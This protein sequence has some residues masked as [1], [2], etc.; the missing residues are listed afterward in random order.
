MSGDTDTYVDPY[1]ELGSVTEYTLPH[2]LARV[3][4]GSAEH[5]WQCELRWLWETHSDR[6]AELMQ[7][8]LRQGVRI[9]VLIGRHP[10]SG[11][12]RM[13]DGHHRVGIAVALALETLPVRIVE[14]EAP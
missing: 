13:W 8:V 1:R 4:V 2:I 5:S 10:Q 14:S 7:K 6:M 12:E 9:P 3:K 11:E